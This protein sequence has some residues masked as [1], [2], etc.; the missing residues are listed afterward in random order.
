MVEVEELVF[1]FGSDGS[2]SSRGVEVEEI[3]PGEEEWEG[4][5]SYQTPWTSYH[6]GGKVKKVWDNFM[7]EGW[8]QIP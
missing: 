1:N 6:L 8:E 2:E 3:K 5:D 4:E 7:G